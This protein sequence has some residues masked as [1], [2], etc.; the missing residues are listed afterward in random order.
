MNAE[1]TIAATPVTPTGLSTAAAAS[2]MS[3]FGPNATPDE[4]LH[5]LR[6]VLRHF[7]APVPW[8][9][10]ATIVLQIVIGER[11]EASMVALLL[12]LNVGLGVFQEAHANAALE[13]LKQRLTPRVRIRRDAEW[14]EAPAA[15]LVPGDIVQVSLGGIVPADL[16]IISGSVLLD[17]SML[18]GESIPSEA[19]PAGTA[20]AGALV[21]RGEAIAEVVATGART[22]FG[23][24]AELVRI[25]KVESSEQRAVLGVVRALTVVNF[26]IVVAMVAY[27]HMIGMPVPSIIPL[28]LTALLSAVPVALPAT[29]TLAAA[30]GAKALALKGVLLTRLSALHEAA[31]IDVLCADK[32]GTLTENTLEL[33]AIRPF[34]DGF[35]EADILAW[36]AAASSADGQDPIDTAIRA[37]AALRPSAQQVD[38]T[39]LRFVPFDPAVKM[40]EALAVDRTGRQIRVAK[41]A[42][43]AVAAV[44]PLSAAVTTQLQHFTELGYRT[45]VV[46]AGPPDELVVVGLI[47]L[48]DPP[49]DDSRHLLAELASLGV[50]TVMVTGDAAATA[51]T[52]AHAIGLSGPVRPPGRLPDSADPADFAVYAGVFP[53]DKFRLV[54]AFQR[55]GH[56]VGMCGDGAN[57]AP[58][59]RQAQMGIAVSTATDVAKAAAGIVLTTPGLAGIVTCIKEGRSAFQ[60]VLTYTLS[61]LVNKCATLFVMGAGLVITG[62]A[63]LTP[64]LQALSMLAGDFVTMS[65]AADRAQ[66]S[67]YPNRWRIRNMLLA[68]IPL[69]LFKLAYCVGILALAWYRWHLDYRHMQTFTF[70]LLVYAGQANVYVL[71][72]RDHFWRSRPAGIMLFASAAD[73]AIVSCLALGGVLMSPLSPGTAGVL[74]VATL[75]FALVLDAIKVTV[76]TRLR[77]D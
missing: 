16:R 71:R 5:P 1:Q 8:M 38:L 70:L 42:P 22:Y 68:A 40:A 57:D 52:V 4:Q 26:A 37:A 41:G 2:R 50:R 45:L 64:L 72:A 20:Y 7:W 74:L 24:T 54:K 28:V 58:A 60:R 10:E 9:L 39:V 14:F 59:L 21:R 18:T 32:T 62:H 29:F 13:L 77:I 19:G 23:R 36:A 63:V 27:A 66:P 49:R 48:S 69:G 65:R 53:E 33:T 55:T 61:I 17:Q 35:G 47:A 3:R 31:M 75:L 76:R 25:A 46:A 34:K 12:L 11:L 6:R 30:L 56:A 67:Q 44:A 73:V 43:I 51:A 15:E